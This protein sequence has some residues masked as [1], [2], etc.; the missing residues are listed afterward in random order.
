MLT[1]YIMLYFRVE[2]GYLTSVYIYTSIEVIFKL[3]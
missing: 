3:K 1:Q 2:G